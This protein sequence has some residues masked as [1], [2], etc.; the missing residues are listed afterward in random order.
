MRSAQRAESGRARDVLRGSRGLSRRMCCGTVPV[1]PFFLVFPHFSPFLRPAPLP[2]RHH[3]GVGYAE[4]APSPCPAPPHW[5]MGGRRGA[6]VTGRCCGRRCGRA[7]CVRRCAVSACPAARR[8]CRDRALRRRTCRVRPR[9]AGAAGWGTALP[10]HYG[11]HRRGALLGGDVPW[12]ARRSACPAPLVPGQGPGGC[13]CE[14]GPGQSW[15]SAVRQHQI[16]R[17]RE[18]S[19]CSHKLPLARW[20]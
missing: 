15:R 7:G 2:P 19:Q 6:D 20:L 4:G 10:G 12:C 8:P 5:P 16:R 17:E 13:A 9:G 14:R 3:G 11:P 18:K 1:I